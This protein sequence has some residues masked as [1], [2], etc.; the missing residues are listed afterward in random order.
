[1][2]LKTTR[3][4]F[5]ACATILGVAAWVPAM[6]AALADAPQRAGEDRVCEWK[7]IFR[8]VALCEASATEPRPIQIRAVR[9]DLRE[10]TID[11]LVTPSNGDEDL[12]TGARRTSEFLEEFKCQVAINGSA[13]KPF[14]GRRG[15]PQEVLGLS[16]S[17][18]DL[19]SK[20]AGNYDALLISRDRRARIARP[21]IDTEGA[22]NGLSGFNALMID[23]RIVARGEA[24]H[25]RSAVGITKDDRYLI[26]MTIDGRQPGRSEGTSLP[27][28]AEWMRRLG[29]HNALNLD[30]GGST[31]LVIEGP[32]GKPKVVNRPV[33][34]S[35]RRVANHLGVIARP[36]GEPG[37][38]GEEP[39]GELP[40]S[41]D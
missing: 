33:G 39:A 29:A 7:P 3:R 17:R 38:D 5:L 20:P 41:P 6:P 10:P 12:D 4:W 18:G 26:L 13:F 32:D 34:I 21:P 14:A 37:P 22:Y 19:Y 15:E 35:E 23:G 30:G 11:F 31:T 8:G 2:K 1:M 24:I 36:L 40:A 16:L 28:T 25:P 9:V 27:E